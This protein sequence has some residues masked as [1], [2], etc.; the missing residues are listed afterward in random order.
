MFLYANEYPLGIRILCALLIV[1]F[2]SILKYGSNI[3]A[4]IINYHKTAKQKRA[5]MQKLQELSPSVAQAINDILEDSISD[6]ERSQKVFNIVQDMD[7]TIQN[8]IKRYTL[9][10]LSHRKKLSCRFLLEKQDTYL[11]DFS[12]LKD[13]TIDKD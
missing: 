2:F 1:L 10:W 3:I 9:A 4:M 6:S 8:T 12:W 7:K 11:N 5:Y 13:F